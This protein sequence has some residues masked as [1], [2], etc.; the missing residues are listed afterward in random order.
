MPLNINR[1]YKFVVIVFIILLSDYL[2]SFFIKNKNFWNQ[3][4]PDKYWRVPSYV[5]HHDLKAN[6]DATESWGS[7]QYK[8]ITNSLG[9]RDFKNRNIL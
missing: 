2:F 8:F 9:F 5:Y 3:I 1:F 6:V 7:Y 4:Y